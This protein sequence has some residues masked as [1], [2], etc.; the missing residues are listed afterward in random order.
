MKKLILILMS[1]LVFS[2]MVLAQAAPD[3]TRLSVGARYLGMGKAFVGLADDVGSLYLNPAGLAN[4]NRWQATSMQG[5][6]LEEFNY[7][8]FSGVYPTNYG[9]FG[10]GLSDARIGGAPVT[11][12]KAGSDPDDPIYEVDPN[13]PEG[14]AYVNDVFIVSYANKLE[15]LFERVAFTRD[16]TQ[17]M[18]WLKTMSVGAN[19]KI[20]STSITGNGITQGGATGT[21][22]D[23]AMHAKPLKYLSVGANLQNALPKSMGGK[24]VYQSGWEESYPAVLKIGTALNVLSPDDDGLRALGLH[25]AKLLLDL[26]WEPMRP[27]VPIITHLGVEWMP[28]DLVALRVGV[29]Q[30]MVGPGTTASN[31]TAGVGVYYRGFRFDY[32]YHQFAGAPGVDNHFFSLSYGIFIEKKAR[33]YV[34]II[35]PADML[36]TRENKI[37]LRAEILDPEV[38]EA[39][40]Q[41][42]AIKLAAKSN[43][44]EADVPLEITGKN[45]V[46]V[47]VFDKSGKF[48]Q[49]KKVRALKLMAYPDVKA[50]YWATEQVSYIGTLGI[51]K[52]YPD[53]NFKP[54]GNITRAEMS[55][56][57]IRTKTSG[58]AGVPAATLQ[59]FKDVG[60]THWAVKY[61]NLAAKT[62]IVK[63]YP[64]GTFKPGAN[65]TR[66]EGLAMVSRFGSVKELK[67]I[68]SDFADVPPTHWAYPI[69]S[70]AFTEGM[71]GHFANKPFQPEKKLTRSEAVEIL[72][73]SSPVKGLVADL[74]NFERGYEVASPSQKGTTPTAGAPSAPVPKPKAPGK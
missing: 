70:G 10:L 25:R 23:L 49:A 15:K 27:L 33:E 41:G 1:L 5:K 64:D 3:P 4:I 66:A 43:T 2:G 50:P 26:D 54:E 42:R 11:R 21:E 65:I 24:L 22:M 60:L 62:G 58:E 55:A 68:K 67:A 8:N 40:I 29:D 38:A 57:L 14:M 18:P 69:V 56:L 59:L 16:W 32:A 44:F 73:R 46:W 61:I 51:I 13:Y 7:V 48:L 12:E 53:G 9:N 63:G 74:N 6:L 31:L 72:Y 39:R 52:G 36:I 45:T 30:D 34:R 35:S 19:L 17:R 20:F 28:L 47:E 37:L 71:L